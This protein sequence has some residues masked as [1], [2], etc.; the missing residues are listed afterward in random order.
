[1]EEEIITTT[2]IQEEQNQNPNPAPRDPSTLHLNAFRPETMIKYTDFF[3][4]IIGMTGTGKSNTMRH[5]LYRLR[6]H[7]SHGLV[8]SKTEG[9]NRFWRRHV[10]PLFIF[11][12][13]DEEPI[14][15]LI[16]TQKEEIEMAGG[17][18]KAAHAFI[19]FDDLGLD[20]DLTK[21]K[22]FIDLAVMG[23][24]FNI[25]VLF[26]TQ[27]LLSIPPSVRL[28]S[29]FILLQRETD[30]LTR[31]K[32][33]HHYAGI[34]RTMDLFDTVFEECTIE[35][36]VLVITRIGKGY[37]INDHVFHYK[38]KLVL[39]SERDPDADNFKLGND[40]YWRYSQE[41]DNGRPV[42]SI[43]SSRQKKFGKLGLLSEDT[44]YNPSKVRVIKKDDP[45]EDYNPFFRTPSA[46][47]AADYTDAGRGKLGFFNDMID[48]QNELYQEHKNGKNKKNKKKG[49][50]KKKI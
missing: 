46:T 42:S 37:K 10:P 41:H 49:G 31:E 9:A 1:M 28:N 18:D 12:E 24:H 39:A 35:N 27:Y 29:R 19:V 11:T 44:S 43:F 50:K 2:T 38:P 25:C 26:S 13:F 36:E 23:R 47:Y 21:S 33:F 6:H 16:E 40:E 14:Y 5:I 4:T 20:I 7:F 17:N 3:A 30:Y 15:S 48:K 32:L 22:A 34:L 45:E 8:Y